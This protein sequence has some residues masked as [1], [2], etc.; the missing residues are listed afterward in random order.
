MSRILYIEDN[1]LNLRLVEKILTGAGHS[2]LSAADGKRG[3]EMATGYLPDLILVD[4]SLPDMDGLEVVRQLKAHPR[5]AQIPVLALTPD[6]TY[7]DRDSCLAAGYNGYLVKPVSR[8]EFLNTIIYFLM[9]D[10]PLA[11]V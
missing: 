11:G 1:A 2:L 7:S 6:V 5:L 3:L 10:N 8:Q 9:R 4:T